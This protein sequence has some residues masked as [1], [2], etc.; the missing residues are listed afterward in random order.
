MMTLDTFGKRLVAARKK[1]NLT[2]R[3]LAEK[4]DITPTRLNYWEKD[5]REPDVEMIKRIA[6][7]LQVDPNFLVGIWTKDM[8]EDF[9]HAKT[10]E[11]RLYLFNL[12]GVP[13][14][15]SGVYRLLTSLP[16]DN[17]S[18]DELNLISLYRELNSEGQKKLIDFADDLVAT[19]KY[20]KSDSDD[21][22]QGKHA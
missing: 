3:E 10:D 8:Y 7:E 19:G 5:K 2:Q 6:R 9:Q 16:N 18:E 20:I 11:E 15:Y 22:V 14:E 4:L 12:R 17:I 1:L 13:S 21:L